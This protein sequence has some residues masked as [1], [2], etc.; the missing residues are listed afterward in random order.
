[1][2]KVLFAIILG[3]SLNIYCKQLRYRIKNNSDQILSIRLLADRSMHNIIKDPAQDNSIYQ[4][5][6]TFI[7]HQTATVDFSISGKSTTW[8]VIK[9]H[10][11]I[12]AIQVESQELQPHSQP[13]LQT[14]EVAREDARKNITLDIKNPSQAGG[15]VVIDYQS[16]N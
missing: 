13:Q 9:K 10:W 6:I 11:G 4:A 8:G 1:M 16:D 2:K 3:A 12:A 5:G 7:P 15:K 14:I